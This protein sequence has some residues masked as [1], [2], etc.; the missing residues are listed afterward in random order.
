[1]LSGDS[2]G[3]VSGDDFNAT[4]W[5]KPGLEEEDEEEEE[6]QITPC[7]DEEGMSTHWLS[8]METDRCNIELP[9][10]QFFGSQDASDTAGELLLGKQS[11]S[12][13][14]RRQTK[15]LLVA[16]I[17]SFC[18]L[19]GDTSP[20]INHKIF[21]LICQT[22]RSLGIVDSEFVDEMTAVRSTFQTAFQKLF[23]TAVETV[24]NQELYAQQHRMIT[25]APWPGQ[26]S[27][28]QS[29]STTSQLF[30][31]SHG[32]STASSTRRSF[33]SSASSATDLLHLDLSVQNSRYHKDFVEI[34]RIG[35]GGFASVW[36][37]RN[38]LDDIDYAIKKV[39][40]GRDLDT[41][42]ANPYEK[43]FREIKHLARLEHQNVVRYYA[44]WLE[45]AALESDTIT[46]EDDYEEEDEE[47]DYFQSQK[48]HS[49]SCAFD[50]E[51]SREESSGVDFLTPQCES[52]DEASAFPLHS[53]GSW[54]LYIQMQL[55]P[56]NI[57][58]SSKDSEMR[59]RDVG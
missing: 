58:I 18:R 57:A 20:D 14:K 31:T 32:F 50:F 48:N 29:Q 44:S 45:Y 46:P 11:T 2:S 30:N 23:Y 47:T 13:S 52:P 36:R 16:L 43:I 1:M 38:K 33:V 55:C 40:L 8:I 37:A 51:G 49:T 12:Q 24:R 9:S 59:S 15:M 5:A 28:D 26:S 6:G 27:H 34:N 41:S 35:K 19:Y 39:N 10:I 22:L 42:R 54:I 25:Q 7:N 21:F 3:S 4:F 53:Q 56:G 17:E